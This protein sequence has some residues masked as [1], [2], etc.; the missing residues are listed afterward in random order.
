MNKR[1]ERC[2]GCP[3]RKL[4]RIAQR[5][6]PF[7]FEVK[8]LVIVRSFERTIGKMVMPS[9]IP[10]MLSFGEPMAKMSAINRGKVKSEYEKDRY[11]KGLADHSASQSYESF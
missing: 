6:R 8:T 2:I 11:G 1:R 7:L 4:G 10:M 5:S 9:T 3:Y